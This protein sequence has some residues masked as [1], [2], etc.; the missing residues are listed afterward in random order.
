[1]IGKINLTFVVLAMV[2]CASSPPPEAATAA[3]PEATASPAEA[4][5]KP[6]ADA[7]KKHL[8]E[9]VTYPA[10]REQILAACANTPEFTAGE[11]RWLSDNLPEG[12]YEST[13]KVAGALEL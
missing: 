3:A 10:T 4:A 7:T 12:T 2:A 1:M 11:K 6:D 9:H 8:A 13:D 5:A